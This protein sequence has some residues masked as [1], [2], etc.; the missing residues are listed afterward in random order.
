MNKI[1]A[2]LTVLLIILCLGF[3]TYTHFEKI[4]LDKEQSEKEIQL[5]IIK[6]AEKA[7]LEERE[8]KTINVIIE[9]DFDPETNTYPVIISS[10]GSND[11]DGDIFTYSWTQISGNTVSPNNLNTSEIS[12]DAPAGE[13]EFHLT[14]TDKYGA[15][16]KEYVI[17]SVA[18]E[19]N[20][21]PTPVI[22]Y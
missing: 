3:T 18:A 6:A 4:K 11:P 7:R 15:N 22:N 14:L 17:V 20:S 19:P 9:H 8:S 16:C 2:P 21:C 12:F 10:N 13:Y 5:A 1:E